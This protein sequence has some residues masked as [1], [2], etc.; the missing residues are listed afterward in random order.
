MLGAHRFPFE[1]AARIILSVCYSFLMQFPSSRLR[2]IRLVSPEHS[3]YSEWAQLLNELQ[4][5]VSAS[6]QHPHPQNLSQ[7]STRFHFLKQFLRLPGSSNP[8]PEWR[9]NPERD[10]SEFMLY[11]AT[12]CWKRSCVPHSGCC[13]T[14]ASPLQSAAATAMYHSS[15]YSVLDNILLNSN[16]ALGIAS[17]K[18]QN[19]T[20]NLADGLVHG[21]NKQ[22]KTVH[23]FVREPFEHFYNHSHD[24]HPLHSEPPRSTAAHIPLAKP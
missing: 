1:F 7:L 14:V 12:R 10:R 2:H 16:L 4:Q 9:W 17:C 24:A 13:S 18:I 20:V 6:S 3:Q 19:E 11:P 21:Q 8:H 5:R 23:H 15:C 22:G